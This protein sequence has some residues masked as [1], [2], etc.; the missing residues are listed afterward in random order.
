MSMD[1][2]THLRLMFT[3]LRHQFELEGTDSFLASEIANAL[4]L[5]QSAIGLREG[6]PDNT[7]SD[8]ISAFQMMA[9]YIEEEENEEEAE[10]AARLREEQR[11]RLVG[12]FNV[13]VNLQGGHHGS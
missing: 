9:G 4:L 5:Y 7:I 6:Q 10:E 8:L 1:R 2:H 3:Q 11:A 12:H 13:Q